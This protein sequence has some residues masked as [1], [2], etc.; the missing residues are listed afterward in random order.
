M[1]QIKHITEESEEPGTIRQLFRDYEKE[2]V[3]NICFQS[4]ETV[5]KD[6]LKKYGA[7]SGDLIL[8]WENDKADG[9]IALTHIA[10]IQKKI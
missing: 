4:F 6:P 5:L 8:A 9:C 2:L 3:E 10:A 7:P 1:L